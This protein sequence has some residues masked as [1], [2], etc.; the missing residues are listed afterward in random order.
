MDA[1][2]LTGSV[3]Y[4]AGLLCGWWAHARYGAEEQIYF[5]KYRSEMDA[6]IADIEKTA[7][8]EVAKFKKSTRKL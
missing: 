8:E 3:A 1:L 6:R 5:D 2:L 4:I 7:V